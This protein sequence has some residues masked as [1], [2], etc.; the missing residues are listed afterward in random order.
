VVGGD[1]GPRRHLLHRRHRLRAPRPPRGDVQ[2]RAAELFHFSPQPDPFLS[3]KHCN[4]LT[5][6]TKSS[7]VKP[8]SGG[9]LRPWC[10]GSKLAAVL[11]LDLLPVLDG[12]EECLAGA[13]HSSTS[14]LNLSTF[15]GIRWVQGLTL[16]HFSA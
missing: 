3:P 10:E 7:Y 15:V 11:D 5:Y 1:G 9:V 6:P 2:G 13:A 4:H 8:E 12:A 16:V 14:Q